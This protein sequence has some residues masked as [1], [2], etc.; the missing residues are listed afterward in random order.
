[1]VPDPETSRI[2]SVTGE[3]SRT[4][5]GQICRDSGVGVYGEG[6]SCIHGIRRDQRGPSTIF[7]LEEQGVSAGSL[8]FM[9]G[10]PRRP[11]NDWS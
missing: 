3:R 2:I 5:H 7:I 4:P 11:W 10:P 1:M 6:R 9:D 8:S